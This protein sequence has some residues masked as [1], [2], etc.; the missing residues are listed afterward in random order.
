MPATAT[1]IHTRYTKPMRTRPVTGITPFRVV[2]SPPGYAHR[3]QA[4]IP[5]AARSL[6]TA[7]RLQPSRDAVLRLTSRIVRDG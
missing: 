3:P 6:N 7:S 2:A 4:E 5:D 1:I